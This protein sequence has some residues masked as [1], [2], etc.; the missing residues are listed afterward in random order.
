MSRLDFDA[1]AVE[2]TAS[3]KPIPQGKYTAIIAASEIKPTKKNDGQ[4]LEMVFEILDEKFKD[5][6]LWTRLNLDNP[7]PDA[8]TIAKRELSSICRAVDVMRPGD[9]SDLHDRPLIISVSQTKRQDNGEMTN[10]IKGFA[11]ATTR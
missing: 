10:I 9:S 2:P 1:T 3:F 4:Y 5:R 7:N 8:V 11:P 6:K